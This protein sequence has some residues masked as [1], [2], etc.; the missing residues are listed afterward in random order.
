[1][2][3]VGSLKLVVPMLT[4]AQTFLSLELQNAIDQ[5]T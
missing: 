4:V 3:W 1:M 5:V 2:L